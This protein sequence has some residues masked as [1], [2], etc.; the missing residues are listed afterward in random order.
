[1]SD[2]L[3]ERTRQARVAFHNQH[4]ERMERL[5]REGQS[6]YALFIGCSDS[7]VVP[8][9][10]LGAQPGD[11][12]VTRTIANTVPPA[13]AG[14]ATVG[15]VLE[16]AVLHLHVPHIIVCGHLDC[17]GIKALDK[18]LDAGRELNLVRWLSY[19]RPALTEVTPLN[20][21]GEARHR[22]IVEANV[23]LQLRNLLTYSC[24]AAAVAEGLNLHGWVYDIGSGS[25]WTYDEAAG[26]FVGE[27][28]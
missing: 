22:A 20:L 9:V 2:P 23:R 12:F 4:R 11:L 21:N 17:G 25:L 1:M 14:G 13:H 27:S 8:E 19:I 7:R 26:R 10:I 3:S 28:E 5:A 15:A 16:Y 6:P 18:R 24:V